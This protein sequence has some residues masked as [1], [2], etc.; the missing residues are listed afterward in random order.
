MLYI[1]SIIDSFHNGDGG[2]IQWNV[3]LNCALVV[4]S[5]MQAL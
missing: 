2:Y 1:E 3:T 5:K 4:L